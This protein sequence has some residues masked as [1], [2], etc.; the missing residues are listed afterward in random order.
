MCRWWNRMTAC[1]AVLALVAAAEVVVA[2]QPDGGVPVSRLKRLTAGAN[3]C[4]WFRY[5]LNETAEHY[6]AYLGAKDFALMQ[7][8]GIRWVR[9]CVA[10]KLVYNQAKPDVPDPAMMG[11]IDAAIRQFARHDIAVMLDIHNEGFLDMKSEAGTEGFVKFW[12]A[13]AKR[14]RSFD[15][16]F[17][18]LEVVNEPTIGAEEWDALQKRVVEAI[19]R[20]APKHTIV[21]TGAGW[22]GIDGLLKLQPLKQKNLLYS[23]HCYDPFVFTHQGAT[24]SSEEVKHLA[25][26]PYPSS[27]ERVA[28]PAAATPHAGARGWVISY[29]NERWDRRK[30]SQRIMSAVDWGARNGVP[31]FCGEFGVYPPR[32]PA[33]DRLRW[34]RDIRSVFD[35]SGIPFAV[36]GYD[37]GFGL[38]RKAA[39]DGS[40]AYDRAAAE[41][42]GLE[43]AR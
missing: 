38:D 41:A 21:V 43:G 26:V 31:V 5:P 37:E 20:E 19:R 13:L 15:P 35:A 14:Y 18:L 23:F 10:P 40:I 30:L 34:L 4:R 9:L 2:A 25:G 6:Q 42:L 17:L 33:A 11:H 28:G 16:E 32:A 7:K 8:L 24:W 29:G 39:A 1:S 12:A 22:G 3:V 36:W 27:P